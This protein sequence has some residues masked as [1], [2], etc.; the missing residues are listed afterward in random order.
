MRIYELVIL[1]DPRITD[2]EMV[3]LT[4]D[5]KKMIT[6]GGATVTKEEQWGRRKLAYPIDK[7]GEG[8]YVMLTVEADAKNP[9]PEVEHRLRQNDK[10]LRYLTVRT[11]GAVMNIPVPREGQP[12]V[13][14]VEEA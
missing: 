6:A 9:L 1:A 10:V 14:R 4:E 8:K 11:D 3:Q 2:E 12:P 13:A 5:Y 7:L